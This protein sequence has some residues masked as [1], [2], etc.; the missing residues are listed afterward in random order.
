MKDYYRVLRKLNG[1]EGSV[2]QVFYAICLTLHDIDEFLIEDSERIENTLIVHLLKEEIQISLR[3]REMN[4][5]EI[6][7][8]EI[9]QDVFLCSGYIKV[10]SVSIGVDNCILN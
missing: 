6:N 9:D 7:E 10:V 3:Y 1:M 2:A 4:K 5:V 8:N